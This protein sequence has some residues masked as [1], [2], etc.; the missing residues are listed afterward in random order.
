MLKIRFSSD[1]KIQPIFRLH[2][3]AVG[4]RGEMLLVMNIEFRVMDSCMTVIYDMA[5]KMIST[6]HCPWWLYLLSAFCLILQFWRSD[7]DVGR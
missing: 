6:H 2:S 7:S 5:V 3:W 1:V 4:E